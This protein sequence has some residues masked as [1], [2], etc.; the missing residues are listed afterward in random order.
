MGKDNNTSRNKVLNIIV[1]FMVL[2]VSVFYAGWYAYQDYLVEQAKN[3]A[4][5]GPGGD[6]GVEE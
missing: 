3:S 4:D 6:Y 1:A 5:Y 2:F